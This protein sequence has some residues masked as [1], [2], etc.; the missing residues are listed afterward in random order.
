MASPRARPKASKRPTL[1]GPERRTAKFMLI[2]HAKATMNQT[3]AQP[4]DKV[5]PR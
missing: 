1:S 2:R 5:R 4:S 3:M